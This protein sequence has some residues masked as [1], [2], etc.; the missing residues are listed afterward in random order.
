MP[1]ASHNEMNAVPRA[2]DP[3]NALHL[4]LGSVWCFLHPRTPFRLQMFVRNHPPPFPLKAV[5]FGFFFVCEPL[6][7]IFSLTLC[8]R[9]SL[10]I[11][12]VFYF[13][14]YFFVFASVIS[15]KVA[16]LA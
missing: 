5:V 6:V 3:C 7:A 1:N 9:C 12:W 13:H 15:L 11:L 2:K 14:F 8:F 16:A 4:L 10:A